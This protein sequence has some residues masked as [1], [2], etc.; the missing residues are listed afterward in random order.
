MI[1]TTRGRY[2]VMAILDLLDENQGNAKPVSLL[3]I[4]K[5]QNISLSYLEQIFAN[6]RRAEIV[7]A[8]KGPGGGYLLRKSPQEI[9][10]SDIIRATGENIKMTNCDSEEPCKAARGAQESRCRTHDLWLGLENH[11]HNYLHSI[12]LQDFCKK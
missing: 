10:I 2:A 6:L 9:T 12:T 5:R 8:A 4:A 11:I 7:K 1:L 3:S